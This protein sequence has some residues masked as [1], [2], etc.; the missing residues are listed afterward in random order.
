MT[1][2]TWLAF[3]VAAGIILI[4]PGPTVLAVI[5][6]SLA[7]GRRAVLPLVAGVILGDVTSMTFSL[8]GLGAILAASATLF[9][10]LKLIGALYLIYLGV[11]LWRS[12][13]ATSAAV[14]PDNPI[15]SKAL[16]TNLFVVTSLNPKGI[17]FFIAF[18]PQFVTPSEKALPQFLILG[19]TFLF[20]AAV[21]TTSYALFSGHLRDKM[22]R[23][24]TLR[25]FNRIG[26][27]VLIGAGIATAAVR[28]ST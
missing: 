25:W 2:Q 17:A 22:Q 13:P 16:L 21:N 26:G 28:R 6:H 3:I 7:H 8:L 12:N 24:E 27:A 1:Y 11:K 5:S 20:L 10:A 15:T 9:S 4:I 19:G 23:I 14:S 18:L